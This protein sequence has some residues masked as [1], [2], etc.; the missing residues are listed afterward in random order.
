[1]LEETIVIGKESEFPLNGMITIPEGDGPFPAVVFVHGSG[2]TN[3]DSEVF[4]VKPFKDFA[5]GL[6][7]H[8]IAGIRYDKRTFAHMKKIGKDKN[9]LKNL[10]V[11][12]ETIEDAI[13]AANQLRKDARIDP[14]RIFIAGLSM[15]GMLAPRIDAEG[16]NFAGLIMMAAP[17]RRLE[18]LM[19]SQAESVINNTKSAFKKWIMKK[20]TGKFHAKFENIYDMSDEEAKST[21]MFAGTTAF[22]WKDMG[23]KT[24]GEYLKTV[25]K[26]VLIM[27]GDG[28]FQ[29]PVETEFQEFKRI[30][31][32]HPNVAFKLYPGLNH[33]FM[34]VVHGD[35][36]R[37]KEEYSKPQHVADYVIADIAQWIHSSHNGFA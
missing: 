36:N 24:A 16:G 34:P 35:I 10:T 20:Q 21:P 27:Q 2:S 17:V 28:D 8:N 23:K 29:V 19:K 30:M 11:K 6:A 15:G 14:A 3:M 31:Q 26:P 7:K 5:E 4:A 12:E 1:M 18:D 13:L 33:V 37:V 9:F 22:Y 25:T 32:N